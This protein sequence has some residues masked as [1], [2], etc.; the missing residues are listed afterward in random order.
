MAKIAN[1]QEVAVRDLKPYER[2]AKIHGKDQIEK[3]KQS[4]QAFGFL[5]PCLIDREN[6]LI[7]GHGRVMAAKELGIEKVP[8][9]MIEDLTEDER[10]AYILADNRLSELGEWDMSLVS[11]ELKELESKIDITLTGFDLDFEFLDKE[12]V[13]DLETWD[14]IDKTLEH[15]QI[16]RRGDIWQ[17]GEHRLMIGDSTKREDVEKLM[18]GSQA[19]L[20]E[21]DPPY[22]VAVSNSKGD[23]IENDNMSD[24]AFD[25]FLFAAFSNAANSLKDGGAFYIW[26]ADSN[27]RQFRNACEEAG[28]KVRQ[29]LIW[30]KNHFTLGRQDYQWMH[31]P[32]LY[33]WKGGAGHYFQDARNL[34]TL[35]QSVNLREATKEELV[36]IIEQAQEGSTI[37]RED[38]PMVDDLH[39]T[40]KP[41]GL[42][43]KQIK[44]ST[45]SGQIVLDLF[46]GSGTTL[47]ACEQLGRKCRMMEF[48]P[49]YAD[50]IIKRYEEETGATA[51]LISREEQ[52]V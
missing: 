1:L 19:D 44:N 16:S 43:I 47:I 46:G 2:N 49:K 8:C 35:I 9:V 11:S 24:F 13:N 41:V 18:D 50:V 48:D 26:H 52:N 7:A 14:E 34:P 20:L 31:E 25:H 30:A 38:R 37:M 3:L 23:T 32:C 10:R 42:I 5:T 12:P 4:I 22:N 21:T 45:V 29:T 33:G 36:R 6:N 39:P 40:M 17:L 15:E 28:L 27:G 51:K